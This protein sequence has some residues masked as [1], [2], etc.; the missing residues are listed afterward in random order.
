MRC[1]GIDLGTKRIGLALSDPGGMIS[2]PEG[3][4]ERQGLKKDVAALRALVEER[5]VGS[6]VVGLPIHMNGSQGPEAEA[7]RKFAR[8]LGNA[9]GIEVALLDERLTSVEAERAL[10][11]SGSRGRKKNPGRVD[12]V[13]AA[14]LLRTHLERC[15]SQGS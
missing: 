12:S 6:V 15:R 2:T 14:I 13:A 8:A 11:E 3:F 9:T 1:L 5:E 4:L 10:R 7:A